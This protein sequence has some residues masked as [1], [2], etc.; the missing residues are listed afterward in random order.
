MKYI[1]VHKFID[2]YK[3]DVDWDAVAKKKAKEEAISAEEIKER[4][5]KKRTDGIKIHKE[6]QKEL[7]SKS[8]VKSWNIDFKK[9]GDFYINLPEQDDKLEN[10][11]YLERPCFSSKQGLIGFPDKIEVIKNTINIED[12]KTFSKIKRTNV[13]RYG[14]KVIRKTFKEPILHLDDC[15][16]NDTCLQLSL[17]MYILWENNRHLK[18]GKLYL[19][20]IYLDEDGNKEK[21]EK[22]E[23]PYLREEVKILLQHKKKKHG[24]KII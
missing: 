21:I 24:S 3:K 9:Q 7:E 22:Q 17:Y 16:Y 6:L 10:G 20:N 2:S 8:N 15:N 14:A 23:V 18:V 19:T 4:W 1:G 12:Y 11:I 5:E 13:E